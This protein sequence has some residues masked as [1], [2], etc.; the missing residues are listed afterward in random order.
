MP[1]IRLRYL[2]AGK[3]VHLAN[4]GVSQTLNIIRSGNSAFVIAYAVANLIEQ[5]IRSVREVGWSKDKE[6]TLLP[7][8][9]SLP[10]CSTTG[11]SDPSFPLSR[12]VL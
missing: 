12:L 8:S 3:T 6:L 11:P 5:S 7:P 2:V 4:Q 10:L 9:H 1:K